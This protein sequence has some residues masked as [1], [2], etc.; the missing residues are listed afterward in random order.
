MLPNVVGTETSPYIDQIETIIKGNPSDA[1]E[2]TEASINLASRP[3]KELDYDNIVDTT[4][5]KHSTL[6]I[7]QNIRRQC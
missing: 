5:E 4:A 3:A 2:V 1:N 6:S 7:S